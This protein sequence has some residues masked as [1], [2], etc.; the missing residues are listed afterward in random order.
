MK[1]S[2]IGAAP[3]KQQVVFIG[4]LV[5]SN[6]LDRDGNPYYL[7]KCLNPVVIR[8]STDDYGEI[9][10]DEFLVREEDALGEAW[11]L[12]D[13]KDPTKGFTIPDFKTDWMQGHEMAI[14]QKET[15]AQW[16]RGDRVSR[17]A[18]HK[19]SSLQRLAERRKNREAGK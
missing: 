7:G 1:L 13:E 17:K 9:E 10:V 5:D 16:R 8:C 11:E 4:K 19:S 15:I 18:E 2:E 6:K 14:F 3:S 12:I